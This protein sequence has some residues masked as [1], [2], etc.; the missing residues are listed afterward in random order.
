MKKTPLNT[1]VL[2]KTFKKT[3][4]VLQKNCMLLVDEVKIR[5]TVSYSGGVLN[6]MAKNDS[7]SKASSML[8]VKMKCLHG[9]PSLMISVTAVHKLTAAFQFTIVKE[10]A[11]VVERSGGIVLRSM[12][13][14]HKINQQNT[15]LFTQ[16][17]ESEAVHPLDDQ[18][19]WFL[20]FDSVHILK[21]IRNKWITEKLQKLSFVKKIVGSF[22]DIKSLYEAEKYSILKTTTL[23]SA[24]VNPSKLQLQN[25]KHVLSIFSDRVVAPLKLQGSSET[26]EFVQFILNWWNT[27]NVSEKG[28]DIRVRDPNRAPQTAASTNLQSFLEQ[29]KASESGHGPKRVQCLTHDT[30]RALVQ[31]TE[32]LISLC[33]HLFSIGFEYVLLRELQSDRIEGEFSVYRQSTGANAF[34]SVGDVNTAF[35][36]RLTRFAASYLEHIDADTTSTTFH[37]CCNGIDFED[38]AAIERCVSDVT[39]SDTEVNSAAYVAGWLERKCQ[40]DLS[41]SEDDVYFV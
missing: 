27:M 4:H 3:R 25:V 8:C 5:P 24:S 35:K 19:K 39:L 12:T 18:R 28:R 23:A 30:R 13:D 22:S 21:C 7:E 26:A 1:Q 10:A 32:G 20:L 38:A 37:L 9:G 14:N 40:D 41:F 16:R 36:K 31:T 17:S 33:R 6:G 15:K 29:F 11:T 2:E 34:M